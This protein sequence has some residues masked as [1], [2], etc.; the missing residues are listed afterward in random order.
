[1]RY[2]IA[3]YPEYFHRIRDDVDYEDF[4]KFCKIYKEEIYSDTRKDENIEKKRE[5]REFRQ[6]YLSE[7]NSEYRLRGL[8]KS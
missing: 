7:I 6:K 5:E 3:G 8:R 2:D 4:E 1:V